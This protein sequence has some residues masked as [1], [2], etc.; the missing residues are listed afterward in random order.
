MY[1]VR[2]TDYGVGGREGE[3]KGNNR[4]PW[5]ASIV[6]AHHEHTHAHWRL[7]WTLLG[8][9]EREMGGTWYMKVDTPIFPLSKSFPIPLLVLRSTYGVPL[10]RRTL[11]PAFFPKNPGLAPF[12]EPGRI[13]FPG[14][15]ASKDPTR[16][17]QTHPQGGVKVFFLLRPC[18]FVQHHYHH[19]RVQVGC[20][21]LARRNY[22]HHLPVL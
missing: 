2:R 4:R 14:V 7:D 18:Y 9:V 1:S 19:H 15:L 5:W 3:K 13:P 17:H 8:G 6:R 10:E 12:W 21:M 16:L 11:V 20:N 22:H